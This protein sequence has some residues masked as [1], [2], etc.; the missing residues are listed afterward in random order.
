VP[1]SLFCHEAVGHSLPTL[2]PLSFVTP[3]AK[4]ANAS[5]VPCPW[6]WS[7]GHQLEVDRA[8]V[9]LGLTAS[10]PE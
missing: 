6:M 10:T 2:L 4:A 1:F 7:R 9:C 8:I 3:G 5:S